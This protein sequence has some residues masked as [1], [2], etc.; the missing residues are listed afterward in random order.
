MNLTTKIITPGNDVTD[1]QSVR[2]QVFQVEQK[3]SSHAD[4]D[5][6][7]SQLTHIVVYDDNIP[8]GTTRIKLLENNTL[9]KIERLSVLASYRGKHIGVTIMKAVDDYLRKTNIKII[10]LDAQ[11]YV[12]GFYERLGYK[13][14][15]EVFK[16][17]GIPHVKMIKEL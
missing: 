8:V 1:A 15:G 16:E 5:G 9:A 11:A 14:E 12:K 17:V 4:F 13:Q 10:T 6:L 7:D 3:I 2:R